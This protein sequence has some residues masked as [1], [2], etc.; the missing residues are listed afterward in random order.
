[1]P[2]S[3]RVWRDPTGHVVLVTDARL[4]DRTAVRARL[5]AEGRP[6]HSAGDGKL[7]LRLYLRHGVKLWPLLS[8]ELY[9]RAFLDAPRAAPVLPHPE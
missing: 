3:P 9:F 1:M 5:A 2:R 7:L 8:L 6:L 4:W